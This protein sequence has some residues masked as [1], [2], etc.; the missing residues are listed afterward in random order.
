MPRFLLFIASLAALLALGACGECDCAPVPATEKEP[1]AEPAGL[2]LPDVDELDIP[3]LSE[4]E[5]AANLRSFPGVA[6]SVTAR[7][8]SAFYS[9]DM[10][11]EG[12]DSLIQLA[13]QNQVTELAIASLGGEVYWGIK[14]GELVHE[15]GWN[16]RVR[17]LCFSSCANYVFPAGREKIIEAGG[18]VGWH[19]S[20][21][22]SEFFADQQGTSSRQQIADSLSLALQEGAGSLS[23]EEFEQAIVYNIALSETRVE[24]ERSYYETIGVDANVS[25]YGL[26]PRHFATT[27]G[28]GG[29]TYALADMEKFGLDSIS[30]QGEQAY[31]SEDARA[32]LGLVLI[33]VE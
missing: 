4:S 10:H 32:L 3:L 15:N 21:R 18:I 8:S 23:R 31:P 26:F 29:W 14:I 27:A 9:G 20:A 1:A 11:P 19:G 22:Q 13:E 28:A 12:Y 16:V 30:Y 6:P 17:G 7:G 33:E 25:V 2:A 5:L 24:L